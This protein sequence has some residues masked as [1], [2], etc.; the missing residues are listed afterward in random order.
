MKAYKVFSALILALLI[1]G[2]ALNA[3]AQI[4]PQ[5]YSYAQEKE[6]AHVSIDGTVL[7]IRSDAASKFEIY[8]ITG[9]LI[10]SLSVNAGATVKVE[11]AKGFYIIKCE[12]WTKRIV[13]K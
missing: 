8:S 12:S 9:Q 2:V 1:Q 4:K 3:F 11:L 10:R 5:I 6:G 7:T 13:I